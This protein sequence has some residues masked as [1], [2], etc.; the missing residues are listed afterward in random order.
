MDY[1]FLFNINKAIVDFYLVF[2]AYTL[3]FLIAKCFIKS[4]NLIQLDYLAVK[5]IA[6]LGIVYAIVFVLICA[7]NWSGF[8]SEGKSHSQ[9]KI[10]GMY[11]LQFIVVLI[12]TQFMWFKNFSD[13]LLLRFFMGVIFLIP[14]EFINQTFYSYQRDYLPSYW[15]LHTNE[16]QDNTSFI[17][18]LFAKLLLFVAILILFRI[19]QLTIK[20]KALYKRL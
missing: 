5:L 4:G 2:G 8:F 17:L 18:V 10:Y 16:V 13:S 15:T 20:N 12:L 7:Q 9:Y 11:N 14:T 3:L 6:F 1:S 19:I